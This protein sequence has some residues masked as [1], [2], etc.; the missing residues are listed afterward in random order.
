[1]ILEGDGWELMSCRKAGQMFVNLSSVI[2]FY[3]LLQ[4]KF[5]LFIRVPR[6][7]DTTNEILSHLQIDREKLKVAS[8]FLGI[9]D[10][11]HLS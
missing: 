11:G 10:E 9:H 7:I 4:N 6:G 8:G 3:D 2:L 1:M 5:I